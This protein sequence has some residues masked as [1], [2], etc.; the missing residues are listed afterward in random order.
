MFAS[1]FHELR[2]PESDTCWSVVPV[3]VS[4]TVWAALVVWRSCVANVRLVLDSCTFGPATAAF[5]ATV[6]IAKSVQV[7]AQVVRLTTAEVILGPV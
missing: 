3:L 5:T 1:Q 2:A 7:V 6:S 4:V